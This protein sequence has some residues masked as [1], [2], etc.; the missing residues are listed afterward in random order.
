MVKV[1]KK[2]RSLYFMIL[3]EQFVH[4]DLFILVSFFYY[5]GVATAEDTGFWT[6]EAYWAS[7]GAVACILLVSSA[8]E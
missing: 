5:N 1:A 2:F 6:P 7:S 3:V 8:L 4:S